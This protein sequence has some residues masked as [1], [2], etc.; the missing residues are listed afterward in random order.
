MPNRQREGEDAAARQVKGQVPR[1][2]PKCVLEFWPPGN[3]RY[4]ELFRNRGWGCSIESR[5]SRDRNMP[6]RQREGEDAATRQ[7]KGQIPRDSPN[8][9]LN[10][11]HPEAQDTSNYLGMGVGVARLSPEIVDHLFDSLIESCHRSF[12]LSIESRHA[13]LRYLWLQESGRWVLQKISN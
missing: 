8:V 4:S 10:S 12:V 5:N 1:D 3:A 2:L 9:H 6:N 11:G 13:T 7:L